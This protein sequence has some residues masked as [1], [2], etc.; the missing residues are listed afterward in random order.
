MRVSCN[1]LSRHV[2]LT[3]VDLDALAR[4]F[5]M[6]VAELDGVER[7]GSGLDKVIIGRVLEVTALEGK[8]VRLTK[9]DCGPHGVRPIICG[10][11]N[12]APDQH[13]AVAL[14]GQR[15]GDMEIAV[16]AVAGIESH[17]MICS[18][19][20]LG[21]SDAHAG[22]LVLEVPDGGLT[23]GARL[24]DAFPIED[25][26]F[27]IDN[28]SLT[29]RP[30]CWGHRGIAREVAALLERP[31]L[32]PAAAIAFTEARP[33][34]LEIRD[35]ASCPRYS[36]TT[37]SGLS[38]APS[39][40]WLRLLL[41]RAGMRPINN[42]VDATNFAMLD[43]GNPMH[44]FDARQVAGGRI[45]VRRADPGERFATL[46]GQ[47]RTLEP[48]DLVIAD[49]TRAV[50]LAGVMGGLDSEI[51]D[52]TTELVLEV[53]NF[54]PARVRMTAQRLG[55]RTESSA[56]FEKSLDPRLV[57]DAARCF[58]RLVLELCPAARVTSAFIDSHAPF[59][60]A[61]VIRVSIPYIEQRLGHAI[62]RDRIVTIL[63]GLEFGVSGDGQDLA[64]TVPSYRATK[65]IGIVD[66][67]VEEVGRVFGYDNIPPE[68]PIVPVSRPDRNA[69]KKF[70]ARLRDY[71]SQAVG[72]DELQTYS[73]DDDAFLAKMR[74]TPP[75]RI[76]LR[77]AI[78]SDEPCMR[79][80]IAP[81]LLKA[82][83]KNARAHTE[84]GLFEL[85]RVFLPRYPELPHQPTTLGVLF[86]STAA[87]E[88]ATHFARA[89]AIAEGLARALE[90]HA[91]SL[92]QGGVALSW[93][94][95]VRQAR[96]LIG[97]AV[98]GYVA[99]L[100]PLVLHH[101]DLRHTGFALELDLDALRASPVAP[102]GYRALPKFPSVFRDFA[103]VVPK[104]IEAGTIA[105]AIATC[106]ALVADVTFQSA[107]A[108]AGVPEGHKSLAWSVTLRHA[109]RTL[110][111]GEIRAVEQSVWSALEALGGRP[112][113]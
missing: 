81:H 18:E 104:S 9:V 43:L 6:A 85:G 24:A 57:E 66:D 93:A 23:L 83:E 36:A 47:V 107:Y 105:A 103:V 48:Q 77:N 22:I 55:L 63:R 87:V 30:D 102:S 15:L 113:A 78:S 92:V 71:L 42:L 110:T 89:K 44:A 76:R 67:L 33:I 74:V 31:L 72:L 80:H 26:I 95:P 10:A 90:R 59:A 98:V 58:I 16:A 32:A 54:D 37:L 86:G 40:M 100:H 65:D 20:E 88:G 7:V 12:V 62:G 82:L 35:I 1:W 61:T 41:S 64:V 27:V 46:D 21:L 29:H 28:K 101:L 50:A 53:A 106:D 34:S 99:E 19:Q 2:D 96:L 3:G 112:R 17:G 111:E 68:A 5:T 13:V 109:D 8:K 70:E 97:D 14:P 60:E 56:R 39:P 91:P 45:V 51:K 73:F 84:V 108:G 79:T 75:E 52:D 38:V 11:P 4:R 49:A 94:H 25:T 69:K